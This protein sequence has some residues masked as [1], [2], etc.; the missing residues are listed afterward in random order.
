MRFIR[1]IIHKPSGWRITRREY[2]ATVEGC[3]LVKGELPYIET[4]DR[5]SYSI[6]RRL[7]TYITRTGPVRAQ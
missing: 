6:V 1:G 7:V 5:Q 4:V 2:R 3:L